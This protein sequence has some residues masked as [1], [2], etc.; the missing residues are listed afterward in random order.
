MCQSFL[1]IDLIVL[2]PVER[3]VYL[4]DQVCACA[5]VAGVRLSCPRTCLTPRGCRPVACM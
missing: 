5:G 3:A 2:F 4:R 1:A